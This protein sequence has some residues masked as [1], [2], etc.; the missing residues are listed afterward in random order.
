MPSSASTGGAC[1]HAEG[2]CPTAGSPGTSTT[3]PTAR[4][5]GQPARR[6]RPVTFPRLGQPPP[7]PLPAS[8]RTAKTVVEL[9]AAELGTRRR[10]RVPAV[11]GGALD[12]RQ[13]TAAARCA[14]AGAEVAALPEPVAAALRGQESDAPLLVDDLDG[15]P[16]VESGRGRVPRPSA[17]SGRFPAT[18]C[19]PVRSSCCGTPRRCRPPSPGRRHRSRGGVRAAR[20]D[21]HGRRGAL[22][23]AVRTAGVLRGSLLQPALPQVPALTLGAAYRPSDEGMLIGGDFYDVVRSSG[24][25]TTFLLGDVCGK[26]VDAAVGTVGCASRFSR[27][28]GS[29]TTRCASWRCSTPR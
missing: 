14:R 24:V 26:G 15:A 5:A 11:T 6:T 23:P 18:A 9:A 13:A 10:D 3:S 19:R 2:R 21:R 17:R 8:G 28:A 16:W 4:A 1:A 29:R 7:G 12:G 22:R 25:T 27:S 20:G